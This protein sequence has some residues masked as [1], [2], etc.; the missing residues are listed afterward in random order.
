MIGIYKITSPTENIYIGQS[1]DIER[2]KNAYRLLCC[3]DQPA[4]YNSLLKYGF[5]NHIF[6]VIEECSV[7]LLNERERYYQELY[8]SVNNGLNCKYVQTKEFSGKLSESTKQKISKA[9]IGNKK[10]LGKKH[11][12]ESKIKIGLSNKGKRKGFIISDKQRKEHSLAMKGG[13]NSR[14]VIVLNTENGIYY[15]CIK[16]A[17]FANGIPATTLRNKLSGYRKNNTSFIYA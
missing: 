12:E 13:M 14:A 7:K 6:E 17:S 15:E 3:K 5:E 10:W 9:S 1:I 2:R 4:L 8:N 16:D 11:K